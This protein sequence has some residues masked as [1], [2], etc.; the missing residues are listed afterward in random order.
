MLSDHNFKTFYS[1]SSDDIP[2]QF[3]NIAMQESCAYD[4]V[5]G[6]FSS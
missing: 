4:R 6:Y 3:Y 5:S 2:E 1:T